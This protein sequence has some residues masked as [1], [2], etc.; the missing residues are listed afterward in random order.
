[1]ALGQFGQRFAAQFTLRPPWLSFES[2]RSRR[3][4]HRPDAA[5][6]GFIHD[7]AGI[8]VERGSSLALARSREQG[9]VD[10]I[11]A[12][13]GKHLNV[14]KTQLGIQR[15]GRLVVAGRTDPYRPVPGLEMLGQV[16]V[17]ARQSRV[18]GLRR[19]R[20]RLQAGAGIASRRPGVVQPHRHAE[21][22]TGGGLQPAHR[23]TCGLRAGSDTLGVHRHHAMR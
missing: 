7:D 14:L 15:N 2:Q 19:R 17:S 23:A 13:D 3:Q 1:M 18:A 10:G 22:F 11:A 5:L 20:Q 4:S 21:H 16:R 9:F 6:L 12:L 8:G